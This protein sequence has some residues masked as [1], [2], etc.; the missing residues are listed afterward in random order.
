MTEDVHSRQGPPGMQKGF[1]GASSV[2]EITA[3]H[4]YNKLE[5]CYV[6][7]QLFHLQ[8]ALGT[9]A[10]SGAPRDEHL[11]ELW[12]T[13]LGTSATALVQA[14]GITA[15]QS[16]GGRVVLAQPPLRPPAPSGAFPPP[17]SPPTQALR[18]VVLRLPVEY[19]IASQDGLR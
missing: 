7:H 5:L 3:A 10:D 15:L 17:H 18:F 16:P 1:L 6:P 19:V 11:Q 8:T 2:V 14:T 4:A 13:R 9:R 12:R